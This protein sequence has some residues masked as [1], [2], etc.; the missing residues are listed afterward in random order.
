VTKTVW[1]R[2]PRRVQAPRDLRTRRGGFC[3]HSFRQGPV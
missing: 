3:G 1:D 2:P